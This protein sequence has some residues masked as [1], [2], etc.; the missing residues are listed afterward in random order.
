MKR[1]I[2]FSACCAFVAAACH[3]K[4]A[5]AVSS[6]TEFPEP[7]KSQ[8]PAVSSNTPEFKAAG[9]TFYDG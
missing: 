6:R 1:L 7:P 5:P 8:Q 9:K 3:K 2:F 4:T